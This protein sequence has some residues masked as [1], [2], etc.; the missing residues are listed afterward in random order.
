MN[1]MDG[2]L[3]HKSAHG[4]V[5]GTGTGYAI[6]PRGKPNNH[7]WSTWTRARAFI[8]VHVDP[9][10]WISPHKCIWIWHVLVLLIPGPSQNQFTHLHS[11]CH[12]I[13]PFPTRFNLAPER[14]QLSMHHPCTDVLVPAGFPMTG[15]TSSSTR[16][17]PSHSAAGPCG[18]V[19]HFMVLLWHCL[20]A[21]HAFHLCRLSLGSALERVIFLLSIFLTVNIFG[22]RG[23]SRSYVVQMNAVWFY[24]GESWIYLWVL[25][26]STSIHHELNINSR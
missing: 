22:L 23:W 1:V 7:Y 17:W 25:A 26:F 13:L 5:H 21:E 9:C 15:G 11:H 18:V 19:K 20:L 12:P 2:P 6:S 14:P 8:Q 4:N 3:Q 16:Q 24:R 10:K